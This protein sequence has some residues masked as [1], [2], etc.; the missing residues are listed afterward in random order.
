MLQATYYIKF[1]VMPHL[2][3]HEHLSSLNTISVLVELDAC[4]LA[5]A[6]DKFI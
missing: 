3:L 4:K 6:W 2:V 5:I 1:S